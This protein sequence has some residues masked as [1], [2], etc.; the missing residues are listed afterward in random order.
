MKRFCML[1]AVLAVV[2]TCTQQAEAGPN[3]F[4]FCSLVL[5]P[6]APSTYC[7]DD[8]GCAACSDYGNCFPVEY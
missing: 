5:C 1:I 7:C 2:L 3:C 4:R 6:D 8:T